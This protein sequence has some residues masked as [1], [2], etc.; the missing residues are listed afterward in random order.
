MQ[1]ACS[2]WRTIQALADMLLNAGKV[3]LHSLCGRRQHRKLF[4]T[5]RPAGAVATVVA[6][7]G[8]LFIDEDGERFQALGGRGWLMLA[9]HVRMLSSYGSFSSPPPRI[10]T[11]G[12]FLDTS[13]THLTRTCEV[14]VA[15]LPL[16]RSRWIASP[17]T[18]DG[19]VDGS[20]NGDLHVCAV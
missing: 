10:R 9:A 11:I 17:H 7:A 16:R 8:W 4:G 19:V 2:P 14:A 13:V 18:R 15:A 5:L 3:W 1:L 6:S 20:Q 12:G